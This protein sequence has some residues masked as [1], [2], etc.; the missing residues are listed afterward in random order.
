MISI[1]GPMVI[2]GLIF[3]ASLAMKGAKYVN[4][5]PYLTLQ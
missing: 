5:I 3:F 2:K 1:E 4:C